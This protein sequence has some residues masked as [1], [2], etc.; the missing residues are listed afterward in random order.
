ME[1]GFCSMIPNGYCAGSLFILL[2]AISHGS[3]LFISGRMQTGWWGHIMVPSLPGDL[4]F[5]SNF[6]RGFKRQ[7]AGRRGRSSRERRLQLETLQ[8]P[9][10]RHSFLLAP[11]VVF[12]LGN[13][14]L[15]AV[16]HFSEK[17]FS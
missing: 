12:Y 3:F 9:C 16:N 14:A 8:L 15:A 2:A 5:F 7:G 1:H 11:A 6:K 4:L 10:A 13:F 17:V